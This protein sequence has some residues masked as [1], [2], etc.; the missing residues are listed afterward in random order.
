[1]SRRHSP[2]ATVRTEGAILAADLLERVAAGD[3]S[4]GGLAP[5]DYGL[6]PGETLGE[7]AS[8]SWNRL[9]GLWRSFRAA[10]EARCWYNPSGMACVYESELNEWTKKKRQ[11]QN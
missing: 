5:T 6:A 8:R 7:A 1:M 9:L 3:R 2:V 10:A 4:L 11:S